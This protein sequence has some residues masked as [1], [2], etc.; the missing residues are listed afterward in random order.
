LAWT[1][2]FDDRAIADLKALDTAIR[3][4]IVRYLEHRIAQAPDPRQYGA[5]L[6]HDL[7]GLWRYQVDDYRVIV[8]LEQD[9]L[10]V[11]V[12]GIGH[13]REIYQ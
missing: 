6:R 5:A 4:R 7:S 2:E 9:R 1:I 10:T 12:I 11:L 8:R 13:R 3:R